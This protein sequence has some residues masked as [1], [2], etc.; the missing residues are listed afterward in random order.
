MANFDRLDIDEPIDRFHER[1]VTDPRRQLWVPRMLEQPTLV[2]GSAQS[3]ALVDRDR[4][5]DRSTAVVRRRSGGGAVLVSSAD[6]VWFDVVIG[7]DDPLWVDDVGRAFEWVGAACRH[8]LARLGHDAEMHTGAS[9]ISPWSRAICFAGVGPGEL[10]LQGAKVVGISQRRTRS[11]AR[12]Q[13][14]ILRR[15]RP[16]SYLDL[17]RLDQAERVA[18]ELELESVAVGLDDDPAEILDAI[19]ESLP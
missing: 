11:S 1:P 15:W 4:A 5:R 8:G 9:V 12:F 10:T 19:I 18:S 3:D 16:S 14:A 6:T 17:F 2:L 7:R 13:T